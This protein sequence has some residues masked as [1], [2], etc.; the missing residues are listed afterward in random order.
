MS[1]PGRDH[2]KV[3]KV[4]GVT[5]VT[6]VDPK[7]VTDE[8]I[9]AV[10]AQLYSLV[11]AEGHDNL[12]LDLSNVRYLSSSMLGKLIHLKKKLGAIK[13]RLNLCRIHPDLLEVFRLSRL[14]RFF[15]IDDDDDLPGA[16]VQR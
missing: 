7:H 2:L 8:D 15:G 5:V 12:M 11:E 6:F 1:D 13:G 14:D 10:G 16:P 3:E 9:Q 4:D